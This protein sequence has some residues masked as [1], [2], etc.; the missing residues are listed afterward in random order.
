MSRALIMAG[1]ET[2]LVSFA[3]ERS[4]DLMPGTT[5][6]VTSDVEA[7]LSD[8]E[9]VI[10]DFRP[11]VAYTHAVYDP[12]VLRWIYGRLPAI[13][14]IHS[15]YLICPGYAL[16][17]RRS[18]K[19]CDR[20]AGPVCIVNAQIERCC[21]GRNPA[22]HIRR[23]HQ[24]RALIRATSQVDVLVG[25]DYMRH[26]LIVNGLPVERLGLLAPLLFFETASEYVLPPAP[27]VILFA[28]RVTPEKGLRDL[29]QALALLRSDWRL[30]VAGDG[31]DRV[32][33]EQ[34]SERLH[35][36]QRVD[37]V[38]WVTPER[39]KM[40]YQR[41]AFFAMPSLWPEPYGR[42]GPE[43]FLH[44]RPVVAYA[45]GGIPDWLEHGKNGYLAVPGDVGSLSSAIQRL[46]E[47][48]D[49]CERMGRQAQ[50]GASL[51]WSAEAHVQKLEA[52]LQAAIHR[53]SS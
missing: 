52:H 29:I 4:D 15:P 50:E 5:Q 9:R 10:A 38:G 28:G 46:L 34:L 40:L 48:P 12:L 39:M 45:V 13:A 19:A 17:L 31:P 7:A 47:N 6:V 2:R 18:V 22:G 11:D 35:V 49:E 33:C 42:V 44:G 23:L 26:R 1:H 27:E 43:A 36:A 16:F 8:I 14:Y 25:S 30:I 32:A 37:F 3:S 53:F 51:R 24:V 41:C 20:T 21:F